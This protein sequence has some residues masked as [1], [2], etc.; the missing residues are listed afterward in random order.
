[1]SPQINHWV[2]EWLIPGAYH[3][4]GATAPEIVLAVS[5]L[6]LSEV[7]AA[8][9]SLARPLH[10]LV[11]EG[12]WGSGR[13]PAECSSG[14][15][16]HS[17]SV[18]SRKHTHTSAHIHTHKT[19][20]HSFSGETWLQP[21]EKLEIRCV[22]LCPRTLPV[23]AR[24]RCPHDDLKRRG[25]GRYLA[26]TSAKLLWEAMSY[27]NF[28]WQDCLW[29]IWMQNTAGPH[30]HGTIWVRVSMRKRRGRRAVKGG[31]SY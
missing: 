26:I 5:K 23:I 4:H 16:G 17:G 31:R 28:R 11:K 29:K 20:S 22:S 7:L 2:P 19:P 21:P 15:Q 9:P 13:R 25:I 6:L 8:L 1:M 14:W 3:R 10:R 18:V 24:T 27:D 30:R 12:C